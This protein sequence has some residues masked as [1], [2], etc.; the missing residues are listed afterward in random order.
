MPEPVNGPVKIVIVTG[1]GRSGTSSVAGTLKR[2][3]LHVPQPEVEADESNPRGYYEP[4]WVTEFH[5]DLLNPI[6][7][8]TIDSRPGAADIAREAAT[9]PEVEERLRSWLST[10]LD[11]PQL[12]IKDP[13][14]FWV[15]DLWLKVAGELGAEI[16]SLTMLRHPTEVVR[17]RDTAYLTQQSERFRRQRETTNIAA[18]VNAAHGTELATRS[19]RRAFVRYDDLTADWRSAMA[20]AGEQLGVTFSADL[21]SRE[22]HPVDDFIDAKL[23]RS[24]VTWDD[25]SIT[26]E[27][28]ELTE[29]TW[30]AMNDLVEDSHDAAATAALER[31]HEDY[32][33]MYDAAE[34]MA[35]DETTA[36]VSAV[37]TRLRARI[38]KK[39]QRLAKLRAEL[40]ELRGR[41]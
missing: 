16:S 7:V 35:L 33:V 14:E 12:V 26:R 39:D 29:R 32:L 3:G 15:H 20:R 17:S 37:R 27:L 1:S 10:Q 4:L 25:F 34:A 9:D 19:H 38:Q 21:T 5:R 8:R 18:W 41:S 23:N 6:P 36:Q 40:K 28:Q 24:R 30:Q 22:H 13:R 2:L 31:A 11:Q